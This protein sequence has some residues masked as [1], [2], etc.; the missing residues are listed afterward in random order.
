MASRDYNN[1]RLCDGHDDLKDPNIETSQYSL[2]FSRKHLPLRVS[3]SLSSLA[4]SYLHV[5]NMPYVQAIQLLILFVTTC[6][7]VDLELGWQEI[8]WLRYRE[9]IDGDGGDTHNRLLE[10]RN[11]ML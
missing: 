10:P 9:N 3:T 6:V 4:P 5:N 11:H 7:M 1:L 2:P 8:K